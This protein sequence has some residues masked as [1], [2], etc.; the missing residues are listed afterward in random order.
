MILLDAVDVGIWSEVLDA[1][2][3]LVEPIR[4]VVDTLLFTDI[5]LEITTALMVVSEVNFGV[6]VVV[7]EWTIDVDVVEVDCSEDIIEESTKEAE[8]D[9]VKKIVDV[10]ELEMI[11]MVA[12]VNGVD[13][14]VACS[15]NDNPEKE[16][17]V[18][19]VYVANGSNET[20]FPDDKVDEDDC[21]M[22][23]SGEYVV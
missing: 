12:D 21:N 8:G 1:E 23:K 9:D 13:E 20:I 15:N 17:V 7:V 10:L 4:T 3:C 16:I 22:D 6:V 5:S 11:E 2:T 19:V 14:T 18:V